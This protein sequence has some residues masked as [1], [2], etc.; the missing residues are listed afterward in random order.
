[1]HVESG[2]MPVVLL[3]QA[4]VRYMILVYLLIFWLTGWSYK[5]TNL[6]QFWS[7]PLEGWP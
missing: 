1:M 4:S 6:G 2:F 5:G 7:L 3:W